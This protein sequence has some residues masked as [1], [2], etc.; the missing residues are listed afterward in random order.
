MFRCGGLTLSSS[1]MPIQLLAHSPSSTEDWEKK[2]RK[3][4]FT[5]DSSISWGTQV[6]GMVLVVSSQQ[7]LTNFPP[8]A[9]ALLQYGTFQRIIESQNGLGWKAQNTVGLPGYITHCWFMSSFSS[10]RTPKSFSTGLFSR[11]SSLSLYK[12]L[13]YFMD[14][15]FLQEAT[16]PIGCKQHMDKHVIVP[17][18]KMFVQNMQFVENHI[19]M[20]S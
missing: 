3:S 13:G 9:C 15:T 7:P 18:R 1:Q 2:I 11:R 12:Y 8:H 4:S 14:C 19:Y 20:I 10:T 17:Q 6:R 5:P 16:F